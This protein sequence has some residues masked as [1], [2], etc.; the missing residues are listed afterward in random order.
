[1]K[2]ITTTVT[3]VNGQ[4]DIYANDN[5]ERTQSYASLAE[6]MGRNWDEMSKRAK[7]NFRRRHQGECK[8]IETNVEVYKVEAT[9]PNIFGEFQLK[10]AAIQHLIFPN[11]PT[12]FLE[13]KNGKTGY[14]TTNFKI[15]KK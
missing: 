13:C 7:A 12:I 11:T 4:F 5:P 15:E 2:T 14:Q 3:R 9:V 6:E 1:M 8:P 10:E